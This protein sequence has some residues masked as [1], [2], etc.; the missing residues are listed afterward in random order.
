MILVHIHTHLITSLARPK[1]I[2]LLP[3]IPI[4]YVLTEMRVHLRFQGRQLILKAMVHPHILQEALNQF[5]VGN[6]MLHHVH[7]VEASLVLTVA[8]VEVLVGEGVLED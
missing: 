4:L 1:L 2:S 3:L 7:M 5:G 8:G 6:G